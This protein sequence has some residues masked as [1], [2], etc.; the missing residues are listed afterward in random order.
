[1][2]PPADESICDEDEESCDTEKGHHSE[3]GDGDEAIPVNGRERIQTVRVRG[4]SLLEDES[5]RWCV[6]LHRGHRADSDLSSELCEKCEE[7]LNIKTLYGTKQSTVA[8]PVNVDLG[9]CL[10]EIVEKTWRGWLTIE[11]EEVK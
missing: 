3:N 1:V 8:T 4:V 11:R 10:L 7:R 9:A 2:F 5:G 6:S